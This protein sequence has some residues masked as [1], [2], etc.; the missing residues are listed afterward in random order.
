M[1]ICTQAK[2][3]GTFSPNY[4]RT[5]TMNR[6]LPSDIAGSRAFL[7]DCQFDGWDERN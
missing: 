6:R 4:Y 3:L 5:G 1:G 2:P 7:V